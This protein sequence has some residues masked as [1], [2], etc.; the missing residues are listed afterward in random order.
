[1]PSRSSASRPSGAISGWPD[2]ASR[3]SIA[4]VTG[5]P[6]SPTATRSCVRA[7]SRI[8]YGFC[9]K[10]A[11]RKGNVIGAMASPIAVQRLASLGASSFELPVIVRVIDLRLQQRL[12]LDRRLYEMSGDSLQVATK[13][14]DA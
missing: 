5:S 7:S 3:S 6:D 12:F 8:G 9:Q 2:T 13:Q 11:V 10:S 1:M 4:N 14:F